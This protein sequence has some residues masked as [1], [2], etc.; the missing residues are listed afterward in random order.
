[1]SNDYIA[2]TLVVIV[3]AV[4]ALQFLALAKF[5]GERR[6]S[7]AKNVTYEAGSEPVGDPRGHFPIRFYP[8]AI[9]FVV[10]DI[11]AAF[12]F[13]WAVSY[14]ELSCAGVLQRGACADGTSALGIVAALGFMLVLLV[15]LIYAW[16]KDVIG[17]G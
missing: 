16:R 11:E 14:R 8:L 12:L 7:P 1:M 13:P 9:L 10:F 5:V 4:G 6:P 15:A 2:V 17:W 3:G